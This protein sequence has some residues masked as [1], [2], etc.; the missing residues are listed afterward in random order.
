MVK[1]IRSRGVN[2][3]R[4]AVAMVLLTLPSRVV[5]QTQ[6]N[7]QDILKK[8]AAW[9]R[10]SSPGVTLE[11]RQVSREGSTVQYHLFAKGL[12][13]DALY[14]VVAW[15]VTDA[16]AQ[17]SIEGV[18]IGKDGIVMC[19]GREPGQCG[20]PSKKDDPIE[21]TF[22]PAKAEPFRLA[23][24]SPSLRAAIVIVPNPVQGKDKG[25]M[26]SV[27]RLTPN[28]ELAY[29]TGSGFPPDSDVQFETQSY[30]ERN[31]LTVKTDSG[32]NLS[33]GTLPFVTGRTKGTATVKAVGGQCSPSLK[34]D[35]GS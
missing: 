5:G 32:G 20:D 27:V 12:S 33:F 22:N 34:F 17:V 7:P 29:V 24:V 15:P 2:P 35:W 16:A 14:Q 23:L 25:C 4:V 28:F 3:I 13:S 19:A 30:D 21:F 11:A 8:H 9:L 10:L 18:S 31:P 6:V 1:F 26:I